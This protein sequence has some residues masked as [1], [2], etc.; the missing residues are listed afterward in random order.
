MDEGWT[1]WIFD[2]YKVGY[3]SVLDAEIRAGN[4]RA[5]Y[6]CIVLPDQG[7]QQIFN[8]LPKER[9]PAEVAGGLGAE[10]VR[11]LKRFVEEGGTIIALNDAS[12]FAIEHLDVPVKNALKGVAPREFYCPGSI[13]KVKLDASHAISAGV[14]MLGS[15]GD[16]TGVWFET[17]PALEV[18]GANA[19]VIARYADAGELLLSGWL[20]GAEKI[21]G[22]GA[23]VEARQ[24]RGRVVMFAF[25]PQYR[26]QSVATLPLLFN[27][28]YQNSEARSQ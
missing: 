21:A 9:Y 19:R 25:R 23:I 28:M 17:S 10:G 24:G 6:D 27:A 26:G 1:R 20:L 15:T 18:T 13:L 16:E 5:K 3:T 4:L 22:K 11:S 2:R 8:G 12:E 7:A 14:P